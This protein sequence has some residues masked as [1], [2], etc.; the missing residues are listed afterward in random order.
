ME[1][2]SSYKGRPEYVLPGLPTPQEV[3]Y[4]GDCLAE[5]YGPKDSPRNESGLTD[6]GEMLLRQPEPRKPVLRLA[7]VPAEVQSRPTASTKV[8]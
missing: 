7:P 2:P 6:I 1:I 3:I 8:A 4:L 5:K